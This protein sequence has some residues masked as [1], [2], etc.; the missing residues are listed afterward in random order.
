MTD[1]SQALAQGLLEDT[2]TLKL[3]GP[4]LCRSVIQA[5]RSGGRLEAIATRVEV[6]ASRL[7]AIAVRSWHRRSTCK[8]V[9]T[10]KILEHVPKGF[11]T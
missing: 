2:V 5:K 11:R 10:K 6:M 3:Y 7:E 8:N 1:L 9:S 4:Q